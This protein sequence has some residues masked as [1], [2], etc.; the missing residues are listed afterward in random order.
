M[1]YYITACNRNFLG[2]EARD[3]AESDDR[4]ELKNT[5]KTLALELFTAS[6]ASVWTSKILQQQQLG[7]SNLEDRCWGPQSRESRDFSGILLGASET[8]FLYL[9]KFSKN[10]SLGLFLGSQD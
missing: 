2:H 8:V 3:N 9:G 4:S 1:E 6:S 10:H 5:P 7:M